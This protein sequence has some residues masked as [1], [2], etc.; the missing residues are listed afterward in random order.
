MGMVP[1]CHRALVEVREQRIG[2]SFLLSPCGSQESTTHVNG[3]AANA[4]PHWAIL[5][6]PV[7]ASWLPGYDLQ[8]TQSLSLRAPEGKEYLIHLLFPFSSAMHPALLSE[9]S[10]LHHLVTLKA[11]FPFNINYNLQ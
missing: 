6:A 5:S 1:A 4:F 2:V 7:A 10:K 11:H 9:N 8:L 3:L